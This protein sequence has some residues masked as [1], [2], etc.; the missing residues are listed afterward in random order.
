MGLPRGVGTG[1]CVCQ[2]SQGA[3]DPRKVWA[4]F[5]AKSQL[6]GSCDPW[7]WDPSGLTVKWL[8]FPPLWF[9]KLQCA[10]FCLLHSCQLFTSGVADWSRLVPSNESCSVV[11]HSLQTRGLHSPRNSPGQ[12]TGVGSCSLL[13][14]I[15]STQRSNPGL[16]YY[17]WILYQLNHHKGGIC[18]LPECRVRAFQLAMISCL[19]AFPWA[20]SAMSY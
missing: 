1:L 13:Q 3:Q 15:F 18:I 6:C 11:S 2:G 14:G 5:H 19:Q 12:N 4:A 9:H 7:G 16:L 17:R 10:F 20:P 8:V